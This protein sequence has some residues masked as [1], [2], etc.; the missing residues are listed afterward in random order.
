MCVPCESELLKLYQD[1]FSRL[2]QHL[3]RKYRVL[4][5]GACEDAVA[6]AHGEALEK[7]RSGFQPKSDWWTYWRWLADKRALDR[8]RKIERE[9]TVSIAT[10]SEDSSGAEWEPADRDGPPDQIAM[11]REEVSREVDRERKR[12]VRKRKMLSEILK[13]FTSECEKNKRLS[14]KQAYERLLRGQK[15]DQIAIAMTIERNHVYQLIRRSREWLSERIRQKDVHE[16]VFNTFRAIEADACEAGR[17]PQMCEQKS[18]GDLVRWVIAHTDAV[19]PDFERLTA[20]K[21]DRGDPQFAD[22]RFH[23]EDGCCHR[24]QVELEFV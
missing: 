12:N 4:D 7:C 1:S 2:C 21:R 23:V 24:C 15:A 8:V 9:K 16:S 5:Y 18:F 22:I 14:Q 6:E 19:C 17:R 10:L 13:E 11:A 3:E 20:Y